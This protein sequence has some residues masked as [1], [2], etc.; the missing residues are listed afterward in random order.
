MRLVVR[1]LGVAA[2]AV[3]AACHKYVAVEAA[4][5]PVGETIAFHI[6]DRGRVGLQ[7]RL[8]PGVARIEGRMMGTENDVFLIS[9]A[10][11]EQLNGTNTPWSGEVVRLERDFVERVQRREFSRSRTLLLAGGLSAAVAVFIAS[12][13]FEA[14]F[15]DDDSGPVDPPPQEKLGRPFRP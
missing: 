8:G 4:T 14:I 12:R 6:S 13:G 10:G 1:W 2:L 15:G 5:P 3:L 7:D 9:V 11:V